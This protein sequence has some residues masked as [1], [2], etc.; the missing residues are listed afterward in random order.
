MPFV[1][2]ADLRVKGK[3]VVEFARRIRQHAKNTVTRE[4]GCISFEVNVDGED[5][6]RFVLYEVYVSEEDFRKH[7]EMPY[8]K[9]LLSEIDAMRD[10]EDRFVGSFDRLTAPNK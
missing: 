10:R 3:H 8:L 1:V 6:C 4:P 5:P 2:I 9:K 7:L